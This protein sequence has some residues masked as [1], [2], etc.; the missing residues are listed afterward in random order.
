MIHFLQSSDIHVGECRT[1]PGYLER[2]QQILWNIL[3]KAKEFKVPLFVPGD[4]FHI[5]KLIFD[6]LVLVGRWLAELD[7]IG[8]PVVFTIGNHDD[9]DGIRTQMDLY[10]VNPY[11]NVKIFTKPATCRV[12]DIGVI[13]LPWKNYTTEALRT[14]VTRLY[15]QVHD[16]KYKV[17]M[18][19]ECVIGSKVDNGFPMPKGTTIPNIPEITYWAIGDIHKSQSA[20]LK[21]AWYAGAPAQ[22]TFGDFLP[23]GMLGVNLDT[24][25]VPQFISLPSKPFCIVDKAEDVKDDAYYM[26][27]GSFEEVVKANN[28]DAVVKTDWVKPQTAVLDYEK[29]GLTEGLPEFLAEKGLNPDE[30]QNAVDW[31]NTVISK[32]I[33][34]GERAAIDNNS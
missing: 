11:R 16:C 2:H 10:Q 30:Q 33:Q 9:I 18:L 4:V 29:I 22:F 8:V 25:T 20:G 28:I 3:D 5:R 1:L 27:R 21:N 14:E 13:C 34:G 31:V 17:V 32:D 6:E 12:G 23:K 19:H 7:Q 26:V 24:P 15:P